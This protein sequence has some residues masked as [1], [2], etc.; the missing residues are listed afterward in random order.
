M[1]GIQVIISQDISANERQN[2]IQAVV[3][4]NSEVFLANPVQFR[5]TPLT[6]DAAVNMSITVN[7]SA[8]EGDPST[9]IAGKSFRL[10]ESVLNLFVYWFTDEQDFNSTAVIMSFPADEGQDERRPVVTVPIDIVDDQVNEAERQYFVVHLEVIS[11]V[12]VDLITIGEDRSICSIEDNDSK[13]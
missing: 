2:R 11:A 6:V 10:N 5:I 7:T 13:I 3:S 12:S 1:V 8:F 9:N 4:R